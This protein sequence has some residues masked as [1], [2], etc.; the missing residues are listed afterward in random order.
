MALRIRDAT[1]EDLPAIGRIATRAFHPST[2]PISAALF[3]PHLR[4]AETA[5]GGDGHDAEAWRRARKAVGFQGQRTVMIVAVDDERRG[6]IAGFAYWERPLGEGESESG[7]EGGEEAVGEVKVKGLDEEA[8]AEM[9]RVVGAAADDVLGK[10][11]V[12][13]TW[14]LEYL[15]VDPNHQRRGVGRMLLNWGTKRA[16]AGEKDCYLF[17]TAAGRP[18]YEA[19]GFTIAK[20]VTIFGAPHY[21]MLRRRIS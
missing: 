17:G 15:G 8:F 16:D 13:K 5:D 12:A 21:A 3:P 10:G 2:D 11:G 20:D 9:K 1:W 19:A 4:E 14:H 18:L 6:D 7:E